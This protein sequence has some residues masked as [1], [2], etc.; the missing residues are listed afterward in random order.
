MTAKIEML[1][2][3]PVKGLS[4]QRLDHV[5]L[6]P[7]QGFPLDRA[8]G[9]ARRGSGF[10]PENPRPLPK[11]KFVVLA[12]D[13][14]LALLE[15]RYDDGTQML[16]IGEAGFDTRT[17]EGREGAAA[18][19]AAHLGY[20]A[21]MQPTLHSAGPHK[22][23]DVSVVSEAMMNAVSLINVDSV[24]DF[25]QKVK[26]DISPARFRGNILFSGTAPFDELN[27]EGREVRIG[28]ARLRVLLRT[29]RCPATEVNLETGARD[30]DLPGALRQHY[31]HKD[32]GIYAEVVQGGRIA[33]GDALNLL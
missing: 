26:M 20:E 17:P 23:T 9:F 7:G 22:F 4:A 10:D 25:A 18:A 12:R 33:P 11:G 24:A 27:W 1:C 29:Q 19:I 8:F 28:E 14:G 13:A 3:Y 21:D 15:T 31:G 6:S 30:I 2:H 32:M 5:T 16:H